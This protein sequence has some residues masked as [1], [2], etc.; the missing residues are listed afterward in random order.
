MKKMLASFATLALLLTGGVHASP[1]KFANS[2]WM[3][4][5]DNTDPANPLKPTV[6]LMAN[7]ILR[8]DAAMG[9]K[10]GMVYIYGSDMEL[11]ISDSQHPAAH[12]DV[13]TLDEKCGLQV[14]YNTPGK[15]GYNGIANTA[16]YKNILESRGKHYLYSP[17]IDGRIEK[18]NAPGEGEP[19]LVEFPYLSQEVAELYADRVAFQACSDENLDGIQFDLEPAFK[20]YA[21]ANP[22]PKRRGEYYFYK[23]I[24][25]NFAGKNNAIRTCVDKAHPEGRF[26]SVFAFARNINQEVSD[27]LT[28]HQNGY[29]IDSLYDV[30]QA[31]PGGTVTTPDAYNRLVQD[32]VALM[33]AKSR[34]YHLPFQFGVPAAASVHEFE[35]SKSTATN[36]EVVTTFRQIDYLTHAMR[37]VNTA[38]NAPENKSL[39]FLGVS[40]W[41]FEKGGSP[42]GNEFYYPPTPGDDALAHLKQTLPLPR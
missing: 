13:A 24:G 38:L 21:I 3:Y 5:G 26:F 35:R 1:L 30:D 23:R 6:G 29:F 22:D 15:R 16:K 32:E 41:S 2:A 37:A 33:L 36:G 17:I 14:Y 34:Q 31:A 19:L 40:L 10:L 12:C 25:W 42:W 28:A 18:A 9:N 4:D 39:P 20:D 7:D 8:A 27:A 11:A